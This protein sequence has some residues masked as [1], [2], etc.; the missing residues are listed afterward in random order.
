MKGI[1]NT[2][3]SLI[4]GHFAQVITSLEISGRA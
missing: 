3:S 2:I 4:R 1:F